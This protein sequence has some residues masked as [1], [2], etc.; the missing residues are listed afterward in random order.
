[1]GKIDV[2]VAMSIG[3]WAASTLTVAAAEGLHRHRTRKLQPQGGRVEKS[4]R[5]P[6]E[7]SYRRKKA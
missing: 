1:M 7:S 2:A 5:A 3:L 4:D 6:S